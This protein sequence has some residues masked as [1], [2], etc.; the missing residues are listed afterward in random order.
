MQSKRDDTFTEG[1]VKNVRINGVPVL[2][3][4]K[5]EKM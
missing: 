5:I 3:G 4:F 1:A 2:S